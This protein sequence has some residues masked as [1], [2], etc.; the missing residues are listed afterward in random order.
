MMQY[1]EKNFPRPKNHALS[2]QLKKT[3]FVYPMMTGKAATVLPCRGSK[4]L[5]PTVP[6]SN[7]QKTYGNGMKGAYYSQL[8]VVLVTK[9][10]TTFERENNKFSPRPRAAICVETPTMKPLLKSRQTPRH[11]KQCKLNPYS[12]SIPLPPLLLHLSRYTLLLTFSV[13]H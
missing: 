9:D 12:L 4:K 11:F 10:D 8:P 13:L 2:A 7:M 1:F 3:Y 6:K 5:S